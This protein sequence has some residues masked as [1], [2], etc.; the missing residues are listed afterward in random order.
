MYF[1][2]EEALKE[3]K[4]AT[5][6][7]RLLVLRCQEKFEKAVMLID[8]SFIGILTGDSVYIREKGS[9][10]RE[11]CTDQTAD[12]RQYPLYRGVIQ[13]RSSQGTTPAL[14]DRIFTDVL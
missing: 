4:N 5:L 1:S 11:Q 3:A 10:R 13:G 9:V 7:K 2:A 12:A 8:I 14:H 6:F